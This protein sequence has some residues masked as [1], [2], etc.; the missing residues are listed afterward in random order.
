MAIRAPSELTNTRQGQGFPQFSPLLQIAIYK[1][2]R[3]FVCSL[4]ILSLESNSEADMQTP[5]RLTKGNFYCLKTC[6]T[7]KHKQNKT[8]NM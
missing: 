1:K 8:K 5:I 4:L 7:E 2:S 6:E 3:I